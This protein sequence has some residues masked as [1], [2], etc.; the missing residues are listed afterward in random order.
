MVHD[1]PYRC[2]ECV[3][4]GTLVQRERVTD[5]AACIRRHQAFALVGSSTSKPSGELVAVGGGGKRWADN[6]ERNLRNARAALGYRANATCKH[7]LMRH[8]KHGTAKY[9]NGIEL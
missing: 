7:G 6:A 2:G 4:A 1:F 9:N 3:R 5:A 8:A